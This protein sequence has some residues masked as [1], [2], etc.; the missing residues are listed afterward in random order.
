MYRMVLGTQHEQQGACSYG[1]ATMQAG[2]TSGWEQVERIDNEELSQMIRLP[3]T[4]PV[5]LKGMPPDICTHSTESVWPAH[6]I[7]RIYCTA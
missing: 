2:P 5:A 3:S 7:Q 6:N 1:S 4:A